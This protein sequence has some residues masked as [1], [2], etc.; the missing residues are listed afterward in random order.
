M[1][2]E[3]DS[4]Q[5]QSMK[6]E[7]FQNENADKSEST[8]DQQLEQQVLECQQKLSHWKEQYVRISADF[9]N[10]KKRLEK[11]RSQMSRIVKAGVLSDL[12]PIVDN[13]ER[14]LSAEK[15]TE[16]VEV[17]LQGFEM[18]YKELCKMLHK[19]GVIQMVVDVSFNPE[20]HEAVMSVASDQHD[21]GEIVEVMQMGYLL[22]G[23]VLRPAKVS[24]AA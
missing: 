12:L 24:V 1:Q 4:V 22:D 14:A 21:S 3:H 9:E 13:F 16:D 15:K 6:D 11:E 10:F 5:E 18:I 17:V 19:Q 8:E 23:E 7:N 20:L 2:N